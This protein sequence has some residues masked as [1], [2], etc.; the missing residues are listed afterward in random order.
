MYPSI[1]GMKSTCASFPELYHQRF[2][3]A[4]LEDYLAICV[5][6]ELVSSRNR[7]LPESAGVDVL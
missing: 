3:S 1:K 6:R 5:E 4:I 2:F 7:E